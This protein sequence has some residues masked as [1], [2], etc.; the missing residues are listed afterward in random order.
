MNR[1]N[2]TACCLLMLAVVTR[3]QET[4]PATGGEAI[5][6]N[7]SISF[8]VGQVF[9]QHHGTLQEGV[10]QP[11]EIFIATATEQVE[12]F[13]LSV[14]AYPIPVSH[15]L[16]LQVDHKQLHTFQGLSYSMYDSQGRVVEQGQILSE[17]S[18]I[19]MANMQPAVYFLKIR[20]HHKELKTFKIIK[21]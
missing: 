10:Q 15:L 4:I 6:S 8:S 2:L 12:G 19:N 9:Y 17:Q 16:T 11:Y 13:A 5:G 3:A 18:T 14:Q 1:I 20:N 21:N 7:G